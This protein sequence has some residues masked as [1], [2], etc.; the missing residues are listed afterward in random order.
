VVFPDPVAPITSTIINR[1][2]P[3]L[4]ATPSPR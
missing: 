2:I 3:H 1:I 4:T